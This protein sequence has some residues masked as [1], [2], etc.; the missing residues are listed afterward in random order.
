MKEIIAKLPMLGSTNIPLFVESESIYN[1]F[2][3]NIEEQKK[4]SPSWG[5]N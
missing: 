5:R 2:Y 1:E 4:N 3:S